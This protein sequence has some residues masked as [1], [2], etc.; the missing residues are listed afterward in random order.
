MATLQGR[1]TLTDEEAQAAR[2]WATFTGPRKRME[3][4]ER[5]KQRKAALKAERHAAKERE[6]KENNGRHS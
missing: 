2:Q 4:L 3:A 6:Q 1:G 5:H